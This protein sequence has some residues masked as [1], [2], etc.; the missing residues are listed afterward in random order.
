MSKFT[1]SGVRVQ[2]SQVWAK[3]VKNWKGQWRG[4]N[5]R[6]YQAANVA[7]WGKWCEGMDYKE[8]PAGSDTSAGDAS[9]IDEETSN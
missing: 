4:I 1:F 5:D 6:S 3:H 2:G 9:D 8:Q 7:R